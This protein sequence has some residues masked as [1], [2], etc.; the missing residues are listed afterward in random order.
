MDI[1]EG[2]QKQV[3]LDED[4]AKKVVEFLKEHASSITKYLSPI[5]DLGAVVGIGGEEME[6]L[7][8]EQMARLAE[9]GE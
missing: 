6:P 1:L 3:G 7:T 5:S 9:D 4:K 8:P 2:L